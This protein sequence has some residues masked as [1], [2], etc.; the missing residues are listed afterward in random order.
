MTEK[1]ATFRLSSAQ[2]VFGLRRTAQQAAAALAL[3]RQDQVRLA[4]ALSELGRDRLGSP[5]L[6]VA[7]GLNTEEQPHA[8]VVVL[9]WNG[10]SPPR[11]ETLDLAA[12]LVRVEYRAGTPVSHIVVTQALPHDGAGPDSPGNRLAA[13]L[14]TETR[15]TE[16]DDLRAQTRD[17]IATLDETRAQ[18]E[19]LRR[20][21]DELE[22]TNQGV[23]A[24]YSELTRELETTNSGVLALHSELEDKRRQLQEASEA[25]TR[26][27]TNIS[28]ELR[29]PV[30]A[31]VGLSRL[32]LTPGPSPL[33]AEQ[34]EQVE[35]IAASGHTMLD[36]VS[37][38][39]DV[40]KAEAGHL[41]IHAEPVDVRLIVTH[42]GGLLRSQGDD[43]VRLVVP[44]L[45]D[46]PAL[47]TDETLLVRILRNLLS[48]AMKFTDYGEVRLDV[49]ADPDPHI[50]AL[51]FTIT[52]TGVGIPAEEIDRV[53]EAFY[54]VRGPHQR[55]RPGTGL[56]L[57]YARTLAELLGGS[58]T[59]TSTVGEGT[60]VRVRVPDLSRPGTNESTGREERP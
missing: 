51:I 49:E 39:L 59:L 58:L 19:E 17:L 43:G 28:H 27:W 53:F 52:D 14:G 18:R 37:D 13:A 40:A 16:A 5:A 54:Q 10:G 57:P 6:E 50:P 26:F 48:N 21:N 46:L 35:L 22:E 29:T 9:T 30:N 34:Q 3:D 60:R 31:V 45:D 55:G 33:S 36:L 38:L 41:E 1:A 20:L 32:L 24:L 4:T 47:V 2:E 11:Q 8:F 23:L 25:K 44:R 56:G 15:S 42:L 12:R 7:F